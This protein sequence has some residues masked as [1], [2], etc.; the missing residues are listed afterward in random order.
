M[1]K[2]I[3]LMNANDPEF[4]EIETNSIGENRVFDSPDDAANWIESN[5]QVGWVTRIIEID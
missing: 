1:S 3:I 5:A 2:A 4:A